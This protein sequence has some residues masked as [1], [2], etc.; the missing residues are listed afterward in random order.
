MITYEELLML[1]YD[2]DNLIKIK[3]FNF[4]LFNK[5][6]VDTEDFK[7]FISQFWLVNKDELSLIDFYSEN[8]VSLEIEILFYE[9][10]NN[11][12]FT[13]KYIWDKYNFLVKQ[14]V[15]FNNILLILNDKFDLLEKEIIEEEYKQDLIDAELELEK[16][17]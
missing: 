3:E 11:L 17:F 14:Q 2:K 6:F 15:E 9:Y 4:I 8:W 12:L 16:M 10:F 1:D 7:R 13:S 5:K